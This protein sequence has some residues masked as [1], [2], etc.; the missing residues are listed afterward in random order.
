MSVLS[1]PANFAQVNVFQHDGKP[2]SI[3]L[4]ITTIPKDGSDPE[5]CAHSPETFSNMSQLAFFT[6]ANVF[7]HGG[8]PVLIKLSIAE[9]SGGWQRPGIDF[10]HG[11]SLQPPHDRQRQPSQQIHQ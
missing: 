5:A 11:G 2:V 4:S 3:E 6:H 7:H 10:N 8:Q 1:Q 9:H